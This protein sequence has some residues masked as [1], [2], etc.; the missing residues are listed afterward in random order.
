MSLP[1]DG[2]RSLRSQQQGFILA[3]TLWVLAIMFV[4]VGIFH[5]YVQGKVQ[6]AVNAKT[7]VQGRLDA[8]SSGQTALYL[9]ASSR[10]TRSGLTFKQGDESAYINEDGLLNSEPVGDE[11]WLDGT[12]YQGVGSSRFAIQDLSGLV[13]INVYNPYDLKSMIAR[14]DPNPALQDQLI[15]RLVDYLDLN[16]QVSLNGA[17][18]QDYLRAGMPLLTNDFLRAE[19]ELFRVLGWRE[20]LQ[21]HPDFR[22]QEWLSVRRDSVMNLNTMPKSML[23]GYLGLPED[24]AD[25]LIKERAAN[26][27]RSVEDFV[28][29]TNLLINLDEEKYRFFPSNEYR[30]SVWPDR[31]GQAEV[32]S[33][34]LTPNGV[35]GPW[36]INYQYSVQRVN[37]NNQSATPAM[38][39]EQTRLFG[40]AM[41]TNR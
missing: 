35:Y 20:W 21:A 26:P 22:W 11:L 36:Q 18:R 34:Q 9:L 37:E 13:A 23:I 41:D 5:G 38:A 7:N 29:R 25:Q 15:N 14:F 40:H 12:T 39:L 6:L 17:E 16:E 27:Y 24:L 30:L 33:L 3:A 28:L 32:I 1:M 19:P 10:M 31:G 4:A 2:I 8:Y